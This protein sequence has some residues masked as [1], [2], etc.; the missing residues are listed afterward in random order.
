VLTDVVIYGGSRHDDDDADIRVLKREVLDQAKLYIYV[1][2][3]F[4]QPLWNWHKL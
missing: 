4:A 2:Q 1:G 3:T